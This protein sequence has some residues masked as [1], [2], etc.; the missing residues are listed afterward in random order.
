MDPRWICAVRV[1]DGQRVVFGQA[2]SPDVSVGV[3]VAASCAIPGYYRPVVVEGKPYVDGGV[4]SATN[5]DLAAAL[6]AGHGD[7]VVLL[8]PMTS[9]GLPRL[10]LDVH[11]RALLRAQLASEVSRLRRRGLTVVTFEPNAADLEAMGNDPLDPARRAPVARQAHESA[12][13][14]L[15]SSR[16][17]ELVS[18]LRQP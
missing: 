9:E 12:R 15:R 18:L 10:R 16:L 8:S 3:A 11:A 4:H 14:A 17:A 5:A 2:G 6:P 7:V 1:D 13:Q